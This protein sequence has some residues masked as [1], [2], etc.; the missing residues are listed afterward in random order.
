MTKVLV[1][2]G[3]QKKR[4]EEEEGDSQGV[5]GTRSYNDYLPTKKAV[6]TGMAREN[7]K[8]KKKKET[9]MPRGG[10]AHEGGEREKRRFWGQTGN[11]IIRKSPFGFF[12]RKN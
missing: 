11:G 4:K 1:R 9:T 5:F 7:V 2:S 8:K 10:G 6:R 12:G 3:Q